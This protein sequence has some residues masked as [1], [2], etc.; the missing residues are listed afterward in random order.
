MAPTARCHHGACGVNSQP[1]SRQQTFVHSSVDFEAR[2]SNNE[3]PHKNQRWKE[4]GAG[5]PKASRPLLEP[6][7]TEQQQCF[8]PSQLC[9]SSAANHST[10]EKGGSGRTA[11]Q[12]KGV[13]MQKVGLRQVAQRANGPTRCIITPHQ[14]SSLVREMGFGICSAQ[15]WFRHY[16][17]LHLQ[18]LIFRVI[19]IYEE[20][21][22]PGFKSRVWRVVRWWRWE[23]RGIL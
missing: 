8:P 20:L 11:A 15:S 9:S 16:C 21:V 13:G 12:I 3:A 14:E 2:H 7:L 18:R 1:V 10:A 17:S 22:S 4:N 6:D 19:Y 5:D 23:Y